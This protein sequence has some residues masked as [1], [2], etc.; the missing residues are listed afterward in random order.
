MYSIDNLNIF[1]RYELVLENYSIS[2]ATI[3]I[4]NVES[5]FQT[6]VVF[7]F[8]SDKMCISCVDYLNIYG[9]L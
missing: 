6:Y 8:L 1:L 3:K 2:Q 9:L 7:A 4:Q 5:F